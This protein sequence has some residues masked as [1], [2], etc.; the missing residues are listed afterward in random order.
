MK[1][2]TYY[3]CRGSVRGCCGVKHRTYGAARAHCEQDHRDVVKGNGRGSY[4]D[5]QPEVERRVTATRV[6]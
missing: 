6:S 4:S 5:R 1:A 3:T 2:T